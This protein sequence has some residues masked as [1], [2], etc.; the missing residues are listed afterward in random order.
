M[1]QKTRRGSV[2]VQYLFSY[3]GI[4]LLS[5]ALIG[6]A[7]FNMFLYNLQQTELQNNHRKIELA[8][9]D[10]EAQLET[11]QSVAYGV[12]FNIKYRPLYF[13]QNK[14]YEKLLLDDFMKYV[15]YS[16]ITDEYFLV[17]HGSDAAY[18]S[19]GMMCPL[20][21]H[22]E[23][24]LGIVDP[25]PVAAQIGGVRDMTVIKPEGSALMLLAFPVKATDVRFAGS[26]ATLCFVT[27]A[28]SL[29]DRVMATTGGLVGDIRVNIDGKPLLESVMAV[30]TNDPVLEAVSPGGRIMVTLTLPRGSAYGTITGFRAINVVA[31]VLFMLLLLGVAV[32][33]AHR[34]YMPIKRIHA[35]IRR[36]DPQDESQNELLSI[37]RMFT[38]AME[39]NR[40][41]TQRLAE[42]MSVLRYQSLR[43]LISG[44]ASDSTLA[45]LRQLG[46]QFPNHCYAMLR[47]HF[48]DLDFSDTSAL[49][50]PPVS[51]IEDLSGEDI[52]YYALP[53]ERRNTLWVI[54]NL[55]D[56]GFLE[57]SV[58]LVRSVLESG[59]TSFTM[60]GGRSAVSS[61][62]RLPV[63]VMEAIDDCDRKISGSRS[64]AP[65]LSADPDPLYYDDKYI[66]RMLHAVRI[67]DHNK[68]CA[69]L[70]EFIAQ[71]WERTDSVVLHRY[72][73]SDVLV[74]LVQTAREKKVSIHPHH[75][76]M[77]LAA[78]DSEDFRYGVGVM[79]KELC[80]A[81]AGDDAGERDV[82]ED[83]LG[84]IR[85]HFMEYDLSLDRLA[86]EFNLSAT[87]LSRLIKKAAGQNYKDYVIHLRI[88]AAKR[89]LEDGM[90]V[91]ETCEKVGYVNI[92]HFIKT[93]KQ[94]TGQTPSGYK[95][96][97]GQTTRSCPKE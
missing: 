16:R 92:S 28:D 31:V 55:K 40:R 84:Y 47:I 33:M 48:P 25:Q 79:L 88:D 93:F 60:G 66:A 2:L 32:L 50:L 42:Q 13:S 21:T 62:D 41:A 54:V 11:L 8:A 49:G 34:N 24:N 85:A 20:H 89:F 36:S 10:L 26:N 52:H 22:M 53:S 68:A 17:Y 95:K 39:N 75:T 35:K 37:D 86:H 77:V 96:K 56:A 7:V 23:D 30:D 4:V 61:V 81:A 12:S 67:G 74:A 76:S 72:I 87:Y 3:I 63:V 19:T 43:L 57:E 15:G 65:P 78:Q 44:D 69:H 83:V 46:V 59:D 80:S 82:S 6:V 1:I 14:Y 27:S 94:L 91:A 64:E 70:D 38:L 97:P 71:V 9:R 29:I 90:S 51:L 18:L 45:L 73:I 5:C 58:D